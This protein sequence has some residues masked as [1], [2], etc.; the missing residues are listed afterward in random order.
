MEL[1]DVL[2]AYRAENGLSQREFAKKCGLSNT[3]ISNL[4]AGVNPQT[5][6]KTVSDIG[7]YQKISA[8]M[9]MTL[10]DLFNIIGD[11]EYIDTTLPDPINPNV[12]KTAEARLL[13]KGVD[14]LPKAQRERALQMFQLM[15][16]KNA[17][18]F[19]KGEND[20]DA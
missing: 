11:Q 18:F 16:E 12:P 5:G 1:R 19:E 14:S 9:G 20:D 13:A 7:T 8:A 2:K 3:H 10:R 17:E 15:F 4:E 6:K